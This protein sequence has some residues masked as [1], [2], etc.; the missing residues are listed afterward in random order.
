MQRIDRSIYIVALIAAFAAG[1]YASAQLADT[2]TSTPLS[3]YPDCV[4][5]WEN[6]TPAEKEQFDA[7]REV[8]EPQWREAKQVMGD[9]VRKGYDRWAGVVDEHVE[10]ELQP[11]LEQAR[12]D[13]DRAQNAMEVLDANIADMKQSFREEW[14]QS[15]ETPDE[16]ATMTPA[17]GT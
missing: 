10:S 14:R 1:T 15:M 4:R 7:W 3:G 9:A 5:G 17:S 2:G 13:L 6:F 16:T 12:Q 8:C 11:R